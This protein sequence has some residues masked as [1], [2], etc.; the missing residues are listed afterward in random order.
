MKEFKCLLFIV[1][2]SYRFDDSVLFKV[3]V[4]MFLISKRSSTFLITQA[5]TRVVLLK[6]GVLKNVAKFT[7]KHL[8]LSL[9]QVE[10]CNF[11]KN[12]TLAQVFSCEFCEISKKTFLYTTALVAACVVS[13][14]LLLL[15]K[16]AKAKK[17]PRKNERK[18]FNLIKI[19][20]DFKGRSFS[21]YVSILT[22]LV[23][24]GIVIYQI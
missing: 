9:L 22:S 7:R 16:N 5:A 14:E 20:C 21:Q 4:S 19:L 23:T 1:M 11:I 17:R 2:W 12:K 15:R 6:K 13:K 8:C 24:I 18:N 10:A 3:K